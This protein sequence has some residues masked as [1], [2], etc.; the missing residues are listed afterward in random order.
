MDEAAFRQRLNTVRSCLFAKT[1]L[2]GCAGCSKSEKY[3]IAEREVVTCGSDKSHQRCT[4]LR[5]LL[6]HNFS[7][8]LGRLQ[9]DGSLPHAQEMR[10]QCG[11]LRGIQSVLDDNEAVR[12]IDELL[13]LSQVKFG[14]LS[15]L[16]YSQIVRFATTRYKTR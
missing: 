9:I 7:F 5:D 6:R 15:E 2:S 12:D 3:S 11:G 14:E 16:P 4:A 10:M 13:T 8:A 1:I